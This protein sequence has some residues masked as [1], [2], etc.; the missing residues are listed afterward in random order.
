MHAGIVVAL[1]ALAQ[2]AKRGDKKQPNIV[3]FLTDDEDVVLGGFGMGGASALDPSRPPT[4]PLPRAVPALRARGTVLKHWYA[5]T[6]VC[7]PSR[8]QILTGRM[9]HNLALRPTDRWDTDGHGHPKQCMHINETAL[10]PGPTFAAPLAAAGYNVGFFGKYLN[11]SPH[12][13]PTGAH[14]YFVNPGPSSKSAA[15]ASGEYYPQFW[16]SI[17]ATHNGTVSFNG[18]RYE[19]HIIA[20]ATTQ[21]LRQVVEVKEDITNAGTERKPFFAYIAPHAPHGAAIPEPKYAGAFG[22][23]AKLPDQPRV[24]APRTPS[25][26][27][28]ATDHHWLVAQQPP[29]SELEARSADITFARRWECLLSYDDLVGKVVDEVEALGELDN[30]FFFMTSDHG[31]HFHELRMGVGKWSV[32]ETDVRVPMLVVGP[33]VEQ[34]ATLEG[35]VGSHIDLAPTWMELA[36]VERPEWMDGRSVAPRLLG[37]ETE[38]GDEGAIRPGNAAY[39]EYHG[40]GPVGAPRRLL[41]S[42][43]NTFRGVR[44]VGGAGAGRFNA[45]RNLLYSEWGGDF[46][47]STVVFRELYDMD[48][49]PWQMKNLYANWSSPSA[50]AEN[51][52]ALEQMEQI[53]RTLYKCAGSECV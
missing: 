38:A 36:G 11:L 24:C 3:L 21:W 5:H 52:R 28:S 23:E 30:T 45:S 12:Q 7:C 53:T 39:I 33:G 20:D 16:I 19:T 46:L 22:S 49:D 51:R 17:N 25:Y 14:T 48:A 35:V 6:P 29:V 4:Q 13:A 34:N 27:V 2:G 32:Y 31:F 1:L 15:D 8:S 40:L 50:S 18:S 10:S 42:F 26:N 37:D 41:D 43:N 47:F 44:L 9:F